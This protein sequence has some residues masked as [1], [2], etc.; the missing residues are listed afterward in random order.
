VLKAVEG[1]E[2]GNEVAYRVNGWIWRLA[3]AA[4][5][6]CVESLQAANLYQQAALGGAPVGPVSTRS[7]PT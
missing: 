5:T 4:C 7:C 3:A 2:D 6:T 1:V